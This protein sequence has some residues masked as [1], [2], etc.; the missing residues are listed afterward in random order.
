[1]ATILTIRQR[2]RDDSVRHY[3][4]QRLFAMHLLAGNGVPELYGYVAP[5]LRRA[6]ENTER[7][8]RRLGVE[9]ELWDDREH[10]FGNE[11]I[12]CSTWGDVPLAA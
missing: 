9:R 7:E 8:L 11:G 6:I 3:C 5:A 2:P 4:R 1:M 12:D 10:W